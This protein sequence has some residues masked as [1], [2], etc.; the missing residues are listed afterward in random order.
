MQ[1]RQTRSNSGGGV[2]EATK[3]AIN[4]FGQFLKS[5]IYK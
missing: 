4:Y 3:I 5:S 2:E 1:E